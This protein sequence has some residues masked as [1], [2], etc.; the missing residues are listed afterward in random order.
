[1]FISFWWLRFIY[2]HL[3]YC[4]GKDNVFLTGINSEDVKRDHLKWALNYMQDLEKKKKA[5]EESS[6]Q[7]GG[8]SNVSKVRELK[9]YKMWYEK[10]DFQLGQRIFIKEVKKDKGRNLNWCQFREGSCLQILG[11]GISTLSCSLWVVLL[12]VL[13]KQSFIS[14]P[15]FEVF[16]F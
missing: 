6:M 3:H 13:R 15:Q 9:T 4:T 14:F 1:M 10:G 2:E 16:C 8:G 11:Q 12:N 5:T 7:P